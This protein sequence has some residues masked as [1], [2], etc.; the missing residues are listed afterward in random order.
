M[1]AGIVGEPVEEVRP[2]ELVLGLVAVVTELPTVVVVVLVTG[3][4][5]VV[6]RVEVVVV[7]V[8]GRLTLE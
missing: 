6:L 5:V 2:F 7:D 8:N 3:D 1:G 4:G